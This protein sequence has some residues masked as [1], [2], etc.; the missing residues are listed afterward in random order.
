MVPHTM[1]F[2]PQGISTRSIFNTVQLEPIKR[3]Y[4]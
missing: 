3:T 1:F 4:L 2:K